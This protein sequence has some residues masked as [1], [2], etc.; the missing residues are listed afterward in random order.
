MGTL[1][2]QFAAAGV[3]IEAAGDGKLRASGALT[4]EL[5]TAIR[6]H[7]PAILAELAANDPGI[8]ATI[9]PDIARRRAKA[10]ALLD[11]EPSRRIAV[12][13]EAPQPGEAVGHVCTA[14]RCV[15]VGEL[16][17]PADKYDAL[18]LLM[19]LGQYGSA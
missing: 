2:D 10:L 5:R 12:V 18:A 16:E 7:K 1:V 15:A 13:A 6:A 9:E 14:I 3:K 8:E 19:L 17:V 11:Q 4:D